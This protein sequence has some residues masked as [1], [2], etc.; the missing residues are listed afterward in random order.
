MAKVSECCFVVGGLRQRD[1]PSVAGLWG[2]R[3]RPRSTNSE[4]GTDFTAIRYQ[5]S[6]LKMA[7]ASQ[8][9]A[10]RHSLGYHRPELSLSMDIL[11]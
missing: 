1:G 8:R 7:A 3:G 6:S 9:S 10:A 11:L 2:N 5:L 4:M